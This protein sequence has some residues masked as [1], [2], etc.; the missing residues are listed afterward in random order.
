MAHSEESRLIN[1][2]SRSLAESMHSSSKSLIAHKVNAFLFH[3]INYA[4]KRNQS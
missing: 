4:Y 1:I 2:G 3:R